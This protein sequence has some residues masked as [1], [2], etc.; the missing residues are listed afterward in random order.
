M[1]IAY[2]IINDNHDHKLL[3]TVNIMGQ[4]ILENDLYILSTNSD[5][6]DLIGNIC[7]P[8]CGNKD[9]YKEEFTDDYNL[10]AVKN[11]TGIKFKEVEYL[12]GY[13]GSK[14]AKD[15]DVVFI[16]KSG[17][18]TSY[19]NINTVLNILND[20]NIGAVYADSSNLIPRSLSPINYPKESHIKG[21]VIRGSLIESTVN[22]ILSILLSGYKKSIVY[23]IP[24]I[25]YEQIH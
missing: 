1:N 10:K 2:I 20:K 24:E 22:S 12:Y 7:K 15:Y 19:E 9:S 25:F 3:Q 16:I 14:I 21:F 18:S 23:H 6:W 17:Y 13:I 11:V 8:C 4:F 5:D